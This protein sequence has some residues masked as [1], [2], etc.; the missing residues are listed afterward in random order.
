MWS[1][2]RKTIGKLFCPERGCLSHQNQVATQTVHGGKLAVKWVSCDACVEENKGCKCKCD[3][4]I[5]DLKSVVNGVDV[6]HPAKNNS[7]FAHAVINMIGM[8]IGK[9]LRYDLLH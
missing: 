8:L 2:I 3:H 7:S 6:E 5:E 4:S 1:K 9:V